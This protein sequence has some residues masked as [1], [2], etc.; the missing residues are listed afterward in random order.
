MNVKL[1][2]LLASMGLVCAAVLPVLSHAQDYPSR[3][4]QFIVPSTAGTTGDQL[5]RLL[6][7]RLTQRWNVPVVVDNKV[8]AGG[9]I[10]IEAGAKASPDGYTFLFSATALSTLPALRPKLPYDPIKSF[11]PVVLLG[12]SPLV[13]VVTDSVPAKTVAEFVAYAK[14]QPPGKLN[15]ASPGLGSVHHLTMEMF[16]QQ[17]GLFLTHIPYKG[18]GGAL[19]DLVAGHVEASVVVLQTALPLLQAGKIRMLAVMGPQRVAQFPD[20]PTLAQAGVPNVVSEAWFGVAAPAGT[21]TSVI[22]K[23]NAEINSLMALTEVKEAMAKAGVDPI[24]GKPERL[25][26]LVQ[27]EIKMWNQ[28]VKKGNITAD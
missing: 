1:A 16:K 24:G 5:A 27:S 4:I 14:K 21:P 7:P 28:V 13:L 25:D 12:S 19:N 22:A 11:S 3:T 17:T 6:G 26:A 20:A 9:M 2:N 23:M 15:Y 8:G 10:G 18:T